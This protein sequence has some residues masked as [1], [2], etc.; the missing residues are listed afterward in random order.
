MDPPPPKRLVPPLLTDPLRCKLRA[1]RLC[2]ISFSSTNR[3]SSSCDRNN[4]TTNGIIAVTATVELLGEE[5]QTLTG[6]CAHIVERRQT[7]TKSLN[8]ALSDS[9]VELLALF[10]DYTEIPHDTD[11]ERPAVSLGP[12]ARRPPKRRYF[13]CFCFRTD[14][15]AGRQKRNLPC[16]L[17]SNACSL[18]PHPKLQI[19][20]GNLFASSTCSQTGAAELAPKD[21]AYH[22]QCVTGT[23]LPEPAAI[24]K[25]LAYTYTIA[26]P[27]R[28][29]PLTVAST[30]SRK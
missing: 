1:L 24:Q 5:H 9:D 27:D 14:K 12:F 23:F 18:H 30:P 7:H 13:L 25:P 3:D 20:Y 4:T 2:I 17:T 11:I 19:N 21:H 22:A 29:F 10:R 26:L 28:F 16:S 15:S 6:R 8:R